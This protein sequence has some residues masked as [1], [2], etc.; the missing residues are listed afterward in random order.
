MQIWK[1]LSN[2]F[3]SLTN[4]TF[5][6]QPHKM[7]KQTQTICRLFPTNCLSDI[8]PVGIWNPV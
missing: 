8:K 3:E 4:L 6:P 7:I 2:I 5:K 1:E